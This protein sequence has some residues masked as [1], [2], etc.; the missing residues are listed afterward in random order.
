MLVIHLDA[1]NP[2]FIKYDEVLPPGDGDLPAGPGPVPPVPVPVV[3]RVDL[4]PGGAGCRHGPPGVHHPVDAVP[5]LHRPAAGEVEVGAGDEEQV[6]V[7]VAVTRLPD[8]PGEG[9]RE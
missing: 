9:E 8:S 3:G 6:L 2:C 1:T 5:A 4:P 7:A